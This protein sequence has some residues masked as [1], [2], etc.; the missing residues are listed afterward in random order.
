M[1]HS[2]WVSGTQ[3]SHHRSTCH[4]GSLSAAECRPPAA[5]IP[6]AG[7]SYSRRQGLG[8]TALPLRAEGELCFT[9]GYKTPIGPWLLSVGEGEAACDRVLPRDYHFMHTCRHT[10]THRMGRGHPWPGSFVEKTTEDAQFP[11]G[12]PPA[13][14]DVWDGHRLAPSGSL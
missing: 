8:K 2:A 4:V 5:P 7:G 12:I 9:R 10:H 14:L 6:R 13:S 1:C 3:R 11:L